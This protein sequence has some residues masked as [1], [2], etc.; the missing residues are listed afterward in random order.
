MK[1]II[2]LVESDEWLSDHYERIFKNDYE[3]V[4]AD[5]AIKAIEIIDKKLPDL[6]ISDVFLTG[7]TIFALL[8][9][10]QSYSDTGRIP[11]IL[12][13]AF[14]DNFSAEGLKSYGVKSILSKTSMTPESLLT[15]ARDILA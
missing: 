12:C 1:P 4:K 7:G 13:T 5:S 9:E 10:M 15:V 8:H 14:A 2:L 3:V 11:I 6:I